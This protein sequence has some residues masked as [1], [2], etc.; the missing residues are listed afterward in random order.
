MLKRS[1]MA[2]PSSAWN[3]RMDL[4]FAVC[5]ELDYSFQL[6]LRGVPMVLGVFGGW[7]QQGRRR[8]SE[9]PRKP[10]LHGRTSLLAAWGR[11]GRTARRTAARRSMMRRRTTLQYI[12]MSMNKQKLGMNWRFDLVR[13]TSSPAKAVSGFLESRFR[14]EPQGRRYCARCSHASRK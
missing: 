8:P 2:G 6:A 14:N 4:S 7:R 1:G 10:P 9:I 12:D 13:H 11:R 5:R 3:V